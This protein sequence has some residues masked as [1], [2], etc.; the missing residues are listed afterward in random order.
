MDQVVQAFE[1]RL[2]VGMRAG[3][4]WH[5]K[6]QRKANDPAH[7]MR[8]ADRRRRKI[9]TSSTEAHGPDRAQ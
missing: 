2:L 7:A 3:S 1:Q 8:D 4:K 6:N 9:S 5:Y